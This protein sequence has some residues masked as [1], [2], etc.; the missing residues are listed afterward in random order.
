MI[1]Y[2][3]VIYINKVCGLIWFESLWDYRPY[4]NCIFGKDES[5]GPLLIRRQLSPCRRIIC[6]LK[7]KTVII[8]FREYTASMFTMHTHLFSSFV[9]TQLGWRFMVVLVVVTLV[10]VCF[11]LL[12]LACRIVY[13]YSIVTDCFS[14]RAAPPPLPPPL[15]TTTTISHFSFSIV[16]IRA[17]G[18]TV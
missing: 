4:S 2:C 13:Y 15:T 16:G 5:R 8:R 12:G 1:P 11:I 14:I 18:R 17:I 9:F 6:W 3:I 10:V 7:V